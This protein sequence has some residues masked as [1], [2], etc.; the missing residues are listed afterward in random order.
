MAGNLIAEAAR[1]VAEARR[2]VEA[3]R[4]INAESEACIRESH[5][6]IQECEEVC[7][8]AGQPPANPPG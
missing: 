7:K 8:R 4:L 2:L 5:K 1:K 3:G 6:L